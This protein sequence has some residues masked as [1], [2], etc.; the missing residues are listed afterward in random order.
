MYKNIM[1][2][3]YFHLESYIQAVSFCSRLWT[4]QSNLEW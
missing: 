4:K 1:M 3:F 2:P